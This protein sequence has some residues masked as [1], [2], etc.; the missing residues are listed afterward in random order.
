M[1]FNVEMRLDRYGDS[2]KALKNKYVQSLPGEKAS[3]RKKA[4]K[5]NEGQT[6]NIMT[7]IL[8]H[9]FIPVRIC[10][11]PAYSYAIGCICKICQEHWTACQ[12]LWEGGISIAF[13]NSLFFKFKKFQIR[14]QIF[15]NSTQINSVVQRWHL[16]GKCF[17][18][19]LEARMMIHE[20]LWKIKLFL[21]SVSSVGSTPQIWNTNPLENL[22]MASWIFM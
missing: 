7:D 18:T 3:T 20:D 1:S 2:P 6:F 22:A 12:S 19:V 10:D 13:A 16:N 21:H 15:I 8:F 5:K 11:R 9:W 14:F 4:L 17:S